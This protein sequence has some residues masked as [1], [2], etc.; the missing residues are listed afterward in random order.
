MCRAGLPV[1]PSLLHLRNLDWEANDIDKS[2]FPNTVLEG[3][4]GGTTQSNY[5]I[6]IIQSITIWVYWLPKPVNS[7]L[8]VRV[9]PDGD[10][11][12]EGDAQ[13]V[14]WRYHLRPTK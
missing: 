14:D 11:K 13:T 2:F 4:C 1:R 7:I 8:L 9:R 6:I 12:E 5:F 3:V 10:G